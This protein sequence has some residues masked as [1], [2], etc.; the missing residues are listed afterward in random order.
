MSPV[1]EAFKNMQWVRITPVGPLA[2]PEVTFTLNVIPKKVDHMEKSK[3]LL[4]NRHSVVTGALE[5]RR[6]QR[7]SLLTSLASLDNQIVH[8][9]NE[10]ADL[11]TALCRLNGCANTFMPVE[12]NYG[13]ASDSYLANPFTDVPD[14]SFTE[15]EGFMLEAADQ[16]GGMEYL[17]GDMLICAFTREGLLKFLNAVGRKKFVERRG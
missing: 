17:D 5:T 14:V 8:L 12:K 16:I 4:D 9:T 6:T 2:P 15:A 3:E 7:E 10:Q 1:L 13:E 11:S